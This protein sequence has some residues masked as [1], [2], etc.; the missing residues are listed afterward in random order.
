[1][2][3][4][5]EHCC[6]WLSTYMRL[7]LCYDMRTVD[8]ALYTHTHTPVVDFIVWWWG[9]VTMALR[10]L[11]CYFSKP[12]HRMWVADYVEVRRCECMRVRVITVWRISLRLY[13]SFIANETKSVLNMEKSRSA[14][15]SN[16]RHENI[17]VLLS[18]QWNHNNWN[19]K[20]VFVVAATASSMERVSLNIA[21][22]R[23]QAFLRNYECEIQ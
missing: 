18:F 4:C 19:N 9:W 6:S 12:T 2:E 11:I 17:I 13:V 15:P 10:V 7:R 22:N 3:E 16:D 21:F 5:K 20:I 23:C 14:K 8:N 1:M